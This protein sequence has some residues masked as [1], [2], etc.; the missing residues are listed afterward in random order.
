MNNG[1][2]LE[3]KSK[4]MLKMYDYQKIAAQYME[5]FRECL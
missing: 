4:E 5:L 3:D 1:E 2:A